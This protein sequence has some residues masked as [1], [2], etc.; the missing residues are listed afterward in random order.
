MG[1]ARWDAFQKDGQR[2]MK[3]LGMVLPHYP[4]YS[5]ILAG[6]GAE[7]MQKL[8]SSLPAPVR[9]RIV[10]AGLLDHAALHRRYQEAQV[11]LFTSRTE[12]FPVAAAEALC[13]G[14]TVVGAASLPS[15][16]HINSLGGG[17]VA[18]SRSSQDYADALACELDA[19]QAG[20][21][22]PERISRDWQKRVSSAA[23]ASAILQTVSTSKGRG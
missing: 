18:I 10:V 6:T 14:C 8:R 3:V 4:D 11:I 19:W 17:T 22:D 16:N 15:M 20:E 23:V 7:R 21:R 13:C 5:A 2:F 9:S 1:A 12:G